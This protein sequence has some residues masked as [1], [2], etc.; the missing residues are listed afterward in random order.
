VLC[1]F[2]YLPHRDASGTHW[3][4]NSQ[5]LGGW[6][7]KKKFDGQFRTAPIL[8][9]LKQAAG[10]VGPDGKNAVIK[11]WGGAYPLSSHIKSGGEP[12]GGNFLFE[13]G[14]VSWYKSKQVDVGST[15][16]TGWLAFYKIEIP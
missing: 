2:F 10:T 11:S 9:D 16:V 8:M 12:V 6:A 3:L 4:Y 1:G 5:G 7:G 13:D 15:R 14:H